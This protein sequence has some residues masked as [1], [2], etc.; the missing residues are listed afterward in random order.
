MTTRSAL[1]QVGCKLPR[2][3]S[4]QGR[5]LSHRAVGEEA[6]SALTG[7]YC[8]MKLHSM[9]ADSVPIL[10]CKRDVVGVRKRH[11]RGKRFNSED[12]HRHRPQRFYDTTRDDFLPSLTPGGR[13]ALLRPTN[14]TFH[15]SSSPTKLFITLYLQ[16][17][18][19]TTLHLQQ[20]F[21]PLFICN[22]ASQHSSSPA[23]LFT[24][25]LRQSFSHLLILE[26]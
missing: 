8:E 3:G 7:L 23:E 10:Q 4:S 25:H 18:F 15:H 9:E 14:K 13:R 17:S 16:R 19:L 12:V 2:S 26:S 5:P 6:I 20:S 11:S 24:L 1:M 21:L 22:K